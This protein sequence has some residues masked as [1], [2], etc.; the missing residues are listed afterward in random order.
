MEIFGVARDDESM[1]VEVQSSG[2]PE[3]KVF[4]VESGLAL[5]DN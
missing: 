1:F 3:A 2:S 4:G 5:V